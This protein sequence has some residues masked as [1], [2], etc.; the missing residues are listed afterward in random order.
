[1]RAISPGSHRRRLLAV[2]L[3]A[4]ATGLAERL[5]R[6]VF[7]AGGW[8]NG[9]SVK[10]VLAAVA[11]AW[12]V[13]MLRLRNPAPGASQARGTRGRAGRPVPHGAGLITW[14]WR[15]SFANS[16]PEVGDSVGL[17]G[18]PASRSLAAVH[19]LQVVNR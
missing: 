8:I 2:S 7:A 3:L 11:A 19:T 13:R 4:V 12:V 6:E 10:H 14:P 17:T 16:A 9:H 1:M 15:R 18:T 5:D